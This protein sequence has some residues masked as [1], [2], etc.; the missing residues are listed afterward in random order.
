[1]GFSCEPSRW[2]H[3]MYGLS[4]LWFRPDLTTAALTGLGSAK[5]SHH[6]N[7]FDSPAICDKAVERALLR[8]TYIE[9]VTCPCPERGVTSKVTA[10]VGEPFI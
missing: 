4:Q 7:P 5:R 2:M 10:P 8:H 6:Q 9:V 1:M 3:K